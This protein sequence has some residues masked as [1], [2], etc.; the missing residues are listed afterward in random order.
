MTHQSFANFLHNSSFHQPRV[1]RVPQ[2]VKA[3]GSDVRS[4]QRAFPSG[5]ESMNGTIVKGKDDPFLFLAGVQQTKQPI[6]KR[7]LARFTSRGL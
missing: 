4:S 6:T 1:E 3:Q 2:I 5:F 7:D